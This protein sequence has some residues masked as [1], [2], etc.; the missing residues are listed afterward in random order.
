MKIKL[1]YTN[2]DLTRLLL[3]DIK[4]RTNM[5]VVFSTMDISED[6]KDSNRLGIVVEADI[7]EHD[8]NG[9]NENPL[10]NK[11]EIKGRR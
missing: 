9:Y 6:T 3:K 4:E 10:F 5:I 1:T 11:T 7:N 8:K 2:A